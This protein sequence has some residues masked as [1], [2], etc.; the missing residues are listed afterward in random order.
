MIGTSGVWTT[1]FADVVLADRQWL[2]AEFAA[3]IAANFHGSTEHRPRS[4]ARLPSTDPDR[5]GSPAVH[6]P[7]RVDPRER[8][9]PPRQ[10]SLRHPT[11]RQ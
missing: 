11:S 2:D 10:R 4:T 6:P 1:G 3:I 9:P 5:P 7:H 8:S